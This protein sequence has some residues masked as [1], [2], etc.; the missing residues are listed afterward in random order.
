M[1]QCIEPVEKY[2]HHRITFGMEK[3]RGIS[4]FLVLDRKIVEVGHSFIFE[5]SPVTTM[6]NA[7]MQMLLLCCIPHEEITYGK[8]NNN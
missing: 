8:Y 4:V 6:H 7:S 2:V 5:F 3:G 1:P